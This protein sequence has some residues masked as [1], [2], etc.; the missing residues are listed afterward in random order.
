MKRNA[1]INA[2]ENI[3]IIILILLGLFILYQLIKKIFRGSWQ[4]EDIIIALLIFNIG[5]SFTIALA[6]TK[7][8][9][10]YN[11]LSNQFR[12]LAEDFKLHLQ[13]KEN[14]KNAR[15]KT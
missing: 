7:I 8:S 15:K 3:A 14:I 11:H 12:Y 2:L 6:Q 4:T 9:S 13:Y 1:S 5:F 10:D